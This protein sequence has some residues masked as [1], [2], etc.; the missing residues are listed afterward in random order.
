MYED[1][2]HSHSSPLPQI[3]I[4]DNSLSTANSLVHTIA[5][6]WIGF[7]CDVCPDYDRA[8][9]KLFNSQPPYKLVISGVDLAEKDDFFLVK[10]NRVRQPNIPFVLTTR[11][12]KSAAS[13]RAL[14]QGAFDLIL[15]PLNHEQTMGTIRLALWQS[16][17]RGFIASNEKD[18]K[19]CRQHLAHYP[20]DEQ[21]DAGFHKRVYAV[22]ISLFRLEQASQQ[23]GQAGTHLSD[24]ATSVE[25]EARKRAL[26]RLDALQ[27]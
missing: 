14:E 2:S 15:I 13:R 27:K 1:L 12:A 22:R 16:K 3:L 7:G 23:L 19:K 9:V 10:H 24:F 11:S 20:Q 18:L 17:L 5:D 21:R 6:N 26:A 25:D 8:I 4:A